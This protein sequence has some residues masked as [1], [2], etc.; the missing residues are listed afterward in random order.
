FLMG[1]TMYTTRETEKGRFEP[2]VQWMTP[3]WKGPLDEIKN[4]MPLVLMRGEGDTT[5]DPKNERL[6]FEALRLDGFARASF[7]VVPRA[8]HTHPNAQ[9]FEK[10]IIAL[11]E[12]KP[13]ATP[14]T[15]PTDRRDPL[16]SQ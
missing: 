9:W 5:Y 4:T 12:S 3:Q 13:A 14:T 15:A 8:G 11:D 10:G 6:Q 7:I 2:T 1:G 16:P